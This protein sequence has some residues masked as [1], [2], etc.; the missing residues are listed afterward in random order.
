MRKIFFL[1]WLVAPTLVS[2]EWP[3]P[4]QPVPPPQPYQA[5]PEGQRPVTPL[6]FRTL[7]TQVTSL[8][9]ELAEARASESRAERDA[10]KARI[11]TLE[12]AKADLQL[13]ATRTEI[14]AARLW[15]LLAASHADNEALRLAAELAK[16]R[17][18]VAPPGVPGQPGHPGEPGKPG[19]PGAPGQT[20]TGVTSGV[21]S[22]KPQI[23]NVYSNFIA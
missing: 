13:R 5:D 1:L 4:A 15:S 3:P 22:A 18:P 11:A 10:M 7:E 20:V 12:Q 8:Q 16:G 17:A 6:A 19:Q 14:A 9:K 2:Q 21:F 23:I